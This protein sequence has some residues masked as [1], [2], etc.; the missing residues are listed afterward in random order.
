MS[1]SEEEKE[2]QRNR[3]RFQGYQLPKVQL[4]ETGPSYYVVEPHPYL[5]NQPVDW[6]RAVFNGHP[7]GGVT[8]LVDNAI[9]TTA[10]ASPTI[11]HEYTSSN[12]RSKNKSV[13]NDKSR[14]VLFPLLPP[15]PNQ[16]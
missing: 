14:N 13:N 1:Q 9:P 7:Y 12:E 15:L 16:K 4:D 2:L 11:A 6:Q 3:E 5:Y 8:D 10:D